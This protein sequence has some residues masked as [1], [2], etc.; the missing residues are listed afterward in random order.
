MGYAGDP[1]VGDLFGKAVPASVPGENCTLL[2]QEYDPMPFRRK[3]R[4][5][6]DRYIIKESFNVDEEGHGRKED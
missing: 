2:Y 1:A 5:R 4:M 6:S 3:V